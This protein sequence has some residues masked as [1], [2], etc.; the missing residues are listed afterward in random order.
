M[1]KAIIS[2]IMIICPSLGLSI[3]MELDSHWK[4]FDEI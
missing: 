2:F 3:R 1:L 4:D